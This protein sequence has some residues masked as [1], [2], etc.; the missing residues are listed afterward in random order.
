V[1]DSPKYFVS[2]ARFFSFGAG[3][4]LGVGVKSKKGEMQPSFRATGFHRGL[5]EM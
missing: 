2:D 3:S 5:S 1:K 4:G